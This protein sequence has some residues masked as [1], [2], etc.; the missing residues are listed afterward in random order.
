MRYSQKKL[1]RFRSLKAHGTKGFVFASGTP[2]QIYANFMHEIAER[3]DVLNRAINNNLPMQVMLL[4]EFCYLQLRMICEDIALS[5]LIAHGD[6]SDI[7]I[8][9]FLNNYQA[10]D[11]IKKLEDIHPE[12]FPKPRLFTV[13]A[14]NQMFPSGNVDIADKTS[15]VS[16]TKSELISLYGRC[17]EFLHRARVRSIEQRPPYTFANFQP[18]VEWNNK[19]VSLLDTHM[20]YSKNNDKYLL[21]MMNEKKP[22]IAFA[23][24]PQAIQSS[25]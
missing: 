8:D 13:T 18:V 17:G 21:V 10:D 12:F 15:P 5:C 23:Q 11:I 7:T 14:P 1:Q 20:I 4:H 19:I 6:I 3:L 9:N 2:Q 22:L 16:L 25:A 24:A